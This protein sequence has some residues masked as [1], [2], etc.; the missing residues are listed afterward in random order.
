MKQRTF[1]ELLI[2][3]NICFAV[4][5][6][7]NSFINSGEERSSKDYFILLHESDA[8]KMIGCSYRNSKD[9]P[10]LR[11]KNM[12]NNQIS[13]FKK[14]IDL[15]D[16]IIHNKYGRIYEL[17]NNSFKEMYKQLTN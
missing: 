12:N 13:E 10:S 8:E 17:K 5:V 14:K 9:Y 1:M 11:E 3:Q 15:F 2:N 7:I 6:N 4:C 16:K